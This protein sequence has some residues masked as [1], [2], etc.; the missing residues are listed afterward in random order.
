MLET[1]DEAGPCGGNLAVGVVGGAGGKIEQG[2]GWGSRVLLEKLMHGTHGAEV[3][4]C[5]PVDVQRLGG[6]NWSVLLHF[7][8][9]RKLVGSPAGPSKLK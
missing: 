1:R 7:T 4:V 2:G 5:R 3:G 8:T 6:R 9:K